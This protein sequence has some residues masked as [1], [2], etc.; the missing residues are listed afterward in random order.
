MGAP[1]GKMC[2]NKI[3][4]FRIAT[5]NANGIIQHREGLKIL[6]HD[7]LID[8]MFH[9]LKFLIVPYQQS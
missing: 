9:S 8:I 1:S 7:Q 2:F 6:L 4:W 3:A 5:W